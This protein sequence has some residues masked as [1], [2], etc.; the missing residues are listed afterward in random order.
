MATS[1]QLRYPIG[2]QT[3]STIIEEG[4]AYVDKTGYLTVTTRLDMP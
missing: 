4:Y 3:F 1:Q 2:I